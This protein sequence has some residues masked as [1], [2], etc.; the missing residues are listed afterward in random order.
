MGLNDNDDHNHGFNASD[1]DTTPH[2]PEEGH[3]PRNVAKT[4]P[5][6]AQLNRHI[7]KR[8]LQKNASQAGSGQSNQIRGAAKDDN[9]TPTATTS[10]F[11][12]Y[13]HGGRDMGSSN[14][15]NTSSS[16][17]AGSL[18][19]SNSLGLGFQSPPIS[20]DGSD[21]SEVRMYPI[22]S[23]AHEVTELH[24]PPRQAPS[25]LP[26]SA[27]SNPTGLANDASPKSTKSSGAASAQILAEDDRAFAEAK[28]AVS[29]SVAI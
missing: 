21:T 7:Q 29:G 18:S 16:L 24:S 20:E 9:S 14:S 6:M 28:E 8:H 25:D 23:R 10:S 17:P 19:R 15:T 1:L 22:F 3:S 11:T 26:S 27:S 5:T 12:P 13:N 4:I 2:T